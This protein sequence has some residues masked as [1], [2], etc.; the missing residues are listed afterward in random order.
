MSNSFSIMERDLLTMFR[1]NI[2]KDSDNVFSIIRNGEDSKIILD[3]EGYSMRLEP[4]EAFLRRK[5]SHRFPDKWPSSSILGSKDFFVL[6]T[7]GNITSSSSGN[8]YLF[9]W[10]HV[11]LEEADM[12]IRSS[13]GKGGITK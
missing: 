4:L 8:N 13:F 7:R 5:F 9:P 12:E 11:F 3:L 10:T 1:K 2:L 6:N